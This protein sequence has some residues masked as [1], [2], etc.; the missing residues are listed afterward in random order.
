MFSWNPLYT[1]IFKKIFTDDPKDDK[2][3]V[4]ERRGVTILK[5]SMENAYPEEPFRK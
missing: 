1:V 3:A 5:K 4:D 2:L